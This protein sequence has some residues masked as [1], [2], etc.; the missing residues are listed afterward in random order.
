MSAIIDLYETYFLKD[1]HNCELLLQHTLF[2]AIS[3]REAVFPRKL[4]DVGQKPQH[5]VVGFRDG[6]Q[7]GCSW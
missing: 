5:K 6:T 2:E 1:S 7:F 4:C 3:E